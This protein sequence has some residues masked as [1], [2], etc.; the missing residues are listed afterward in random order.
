MYMCIED[1]V[2]ILVRTFN[3]VYLWPYSQWM[4]LLIQEGPSEV[5]VKY[6]LHLC[7][8]HQ[9]QYREALTVVSR[10]CP[11]H[12]G[13]FD[14]ISHISYVYMNGNEFNIHGCILDYSYVN[15]LAI[16]L[17]WINITWNWRY[18][19]NVQVTFFSLVRT[20]IILCFSLRVW[21]QSNVM[22]R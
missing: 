4:N 14:W 18:V 21:A 19:L 15:F 3:L 6:K 1:I 22:R 17:K 8:R 13:R 11:E 7:Y 2:T 16:F 5:D 20:S 9:K 10:L 12:A